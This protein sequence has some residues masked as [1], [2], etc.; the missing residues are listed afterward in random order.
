MLWLER[1]IRPARLSAED[2]TAR[3]ERLAESGGVQFVMR[4]R[5][6]SHFGRPSDR[7]AVHFVVENETD[8]SSEVSNSRHRDDRIQGS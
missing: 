1:T 4:V 3:P 6:V 5:V 7:V 2:V 8:V